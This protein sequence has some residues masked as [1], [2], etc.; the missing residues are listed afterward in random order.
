MRAYSVRFASTYNYSAP[1]RNSLHAARL[2][3]VTSALQTVSSARLDVTPRPSSSSIRNDFFG[4][5]VNWFR[6]DEPHDEL[7]LT[8]TANIKVSDPVTASAPRSTCGEI[9]NKARSLPSLSADAPAHYLAETMF[10]RADPQLV[11]FARAHLSTDAPI[12]TAAQSLCTALKEEVRYDPEAT[13]VTT[14]AADAFAARAGVCQDFAHIFIAASRNSGV[15]AR[16]VTGYLRTLPPPGQPKLEGADAMHAWVAVWA[17][18]D[19]GWIEFDPTNG[20]I[21]ADDHVRVAVGRDHRDTTPVSGHLLA[22]GKQRH[23][24]AVDVTEIRPEEP[25]STVMRLPA[26]HTSD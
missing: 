24:V 16:Y 6:L 1:A 25:G 11:E 9:A 13:D 18:T 5:A 7:I 8:M 26:A 22:S 23:T 17:G 14:T 10:T 2:M 19:V 3:P 21:V 4:N 12:L 20:C 15:P